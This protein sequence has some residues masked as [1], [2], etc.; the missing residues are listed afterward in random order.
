MVDASIEGSLVS[1]PDLSPIEERIALLVARG[2]S[3][4]SIADELGVSPRTVEWHLGR[5]RRKLER[6]A[7]LHR[8]LRETAPEGG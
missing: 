2:R 4:R 6:T 7:S 1:V 3:S 5:A 8:R